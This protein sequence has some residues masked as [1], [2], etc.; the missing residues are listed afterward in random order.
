MT[1]LDISVNIVESILFA[2]LSLVYLGRPK[3]SR[4]LYISALAVVL[5]VYTSLCNYLTVY[6]G[7]Y[8]I[9]YSLA[10]FVFSYFFRSDDSYHRWDNLIIFALI[11]NILISIAAETVYLFLCPLTGLSPSQISDSN[12]LIVLFT[13]S[14]F[15]IMIV[16]FIIKY[17]TSKYYYAESKVSALYIISFLAMYYIVTILESNLFAENP[18]VFSICSTN[19]IMFVI[20]M[21]TYIYYLRSSFMAHEQSKNMELAY[22]LQAIENS[23]ESY[24]S[25]ESELRIMRHDLINQFTVINEYLKKGDYES[26]EELIINQIDKLERS[27]EIIDTGYTAINAIVSTKISKA[28]KEGIHTF[29]FIQLP[30]MNQRKEYDVAIILGNLIDN[31]IENVA[32]GNKD[33]RLVIQTK[34]QII[35]T[36]SNTTD[37]NELSVITEKP[38]KINHGLGLVSVKNI[39]T[40][41]NGSVNYDVSEGYFTVKVVLNHK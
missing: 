3:S 36:I 32:S 29:V 28:K 37:K 11:I 15:I 30:E 33:I 9:L 24:R 25:Q 26:V 12:W 35:I 6:E 8:S 10:I 41:Y 14:R 23:M 19:I 17:L 16:V 1:Y 27:P 38:D 39:A 20:V 40:S 5:F 21:T 18:E 22:Q 13:I 34:E 2:F 4:L 7:L 31:A